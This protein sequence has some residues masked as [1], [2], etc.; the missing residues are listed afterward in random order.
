MLSCSG[1]SRCKEGRLSPTELISEPRARS[2]YLY[3]DPGL[4]ENLS[5]SLESPDT[6]V[7]VS[8]ARDQRQPRVSRAS[9]RPGASRR[10][11]PSYAK[12]DR[13]GP[14]GGPEVSRRAAGLGEER[15]SRGLG[16]SAA[17]RAAAAPGRRVCACQWGG[18]TNLPPARFQCRASSVGR[19]GARARALLRVAAV[20]EDLMMVQ[21][22][23]P[24]ASLS[25]R[26]PA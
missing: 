10:P 12:A 3:L 23:G 8:V 11:L 15:R 20:M 18:A 2:G 19:R 5:P 14:G 13:I 25:G 7:A 16:R 1:A 17:A 24:V 21:T 26:S 9:A 4:F 6:R 22:A